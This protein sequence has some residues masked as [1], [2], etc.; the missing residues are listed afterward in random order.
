MVAEAK[1]MNDHV[2]DAKLMDR[3]QILPVRANQEV[4]NFDSG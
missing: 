2:Y 4:R 3:E 1:Y